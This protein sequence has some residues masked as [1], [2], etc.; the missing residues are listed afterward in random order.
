MGKVASEMGVKLESPPP[1]EA[2]PAADA[3]VL[4]PILVRSDRR[5]GEEHPSE[6]SRRLM[7]AMKAGRLGDWSWDAASDTI[8]LSGASAEIIGVP[9]G[10]RLPRAELRTYLHPE[11]IEP[12][13]RLVER[14]M[15]QRTDYEME[16]RLR[17]PNGVYAW[18]DVHGTG[19]YGADGQLVAVIGVMQEITDRKKAEEALQG[20]EAELNLISANAPAVLSHW[21]CEHRLKFA[22]RAFADR[23]NVT[24]QSLY[25]KT[26][27]E[28]LGPKAFEAL[29]PFVDRVLA[30]ETV[31]FEMSVPYDQIGL[32][33]VQVSYAPEF[34]P[35]GS[36]RG[37]LAA[38][39]DMTDRR[40]AEVA[41]FESEERLRMAT[42]TG[43]IG[44]WDWDIASNR[45]TWTDS[46]FE[47]HGVTRGE[48]NGTVEG[49]AA[50]L[51]PDDRA[52]VQRAIQSALEHDQRYE[53]EFRAVRPSGAVIWLFTNAVVDREAGRAVRMSGATLDI[54]ARKTAEVALRESESRF[55]VLASH[56][57][58]GIFLTDANGECVFV[59]ECMRT[60][61]GLPC[62]RMRGKGWL[63]AVHPEDRERVMTEWY[64]SVKEKRPFR[65]EY[66]FQ[67]PDDT[68]VWVQGSGVQ[69]G[70][71]AGVSTGHIGTVVDI[72][73][74]KASE[75]A[76]R[77]A[78]AQLHAHAAELEKKVE[79]R[80][81]S[82]REAIAQMEEFSYSVSHDLRA[83]LRAMTAY[84]QALVEDYGDRLDDTARNYLERIRRSSQ[85]MENLTYDVLTYSR[86]A[87]AETE[88]Q[89]LNLEALLRDLIAHYPEL[90]PAAADITIQAPLHRVRAHEPSMG[91]CLANLLTNAAKFVEPGVRPVIRVR[92][93]LLGERV[94]VWVED[95]GI[96]VPSEFHPRLFRVFERVPTRNA[97]EGTGI[98]LA[99]V[100]KAAEKM[101]GR[102]GLESTGRD[103][104]RFW[105]ELT[106]A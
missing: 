81:A 63:A 26:V 100:R 95:N 73:E 60:M 92:T 78:Q 55:R 64:L 2:Q 28:V 38:V 39:L 29:L 49:F 104:S 66:R 96:G 9:S 50:L 7:L 93:E 43:K 77:G 103:G 59:N 84:A 15:A 52:P 10:T 72:T 8:A 98:G 41:L 82:L 19:V 22:S 48:F 47:I 35:D 99:I 75:E 86:V 68:L 40:R 42:R 45:V 24:P 14:A 56:A 37:Y 51:H 94:R 105:I 101:G 74:R 67:R 89:E 13:G 91:Q 21:D 25:G 18:V 4:K 69:S 44:L 46:L 27:S 6:T 17:R 85:R 54:T 32:R 102:C 53:L 106:T 61:T 79:E 33:Y 5:Q 34:G 57:P 71:A 90:Q 58:V 36:V 31:S 1:G 30:G 83:P 88:L 87:R 16:Y 23:W 3:A 11:D 80:T 12:S 20:R 76:L 97:Y 70:N 62:E 65:S